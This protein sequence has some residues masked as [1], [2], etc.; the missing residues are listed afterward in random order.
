MA[1]VASVSVTTLFAPFE[2]TTGAFLDFVTSAKRSLHIVI[3]GFHL[4]KLTDLLIAKQQAGLTISVILDHTQAAGTAEA[5]EVQRLVTAGVPL[6]IG[7]SPVHRQILHSKFAVVDGEAVEFGSWN[8]SLSASQQSNTM[9]F[10][11]G[12]DYAAAFLAHHDRLV[13]FIHL[14][15]M[16]MQPAGEVAATPVIPTTPGTETPA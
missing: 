11:R 13:S 9:S 8:Y 1:A 2:D 15:E 6:L 12:A 3:Y 4:P 7:T 16:T 14:H 10:V 5:G